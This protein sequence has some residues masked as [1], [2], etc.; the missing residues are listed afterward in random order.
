AEVTGQLH[1]RVLHVEA[2][3][4]GADPDAQLAVRG[5][6]P[7]VARGHVLAVDPYRQVAV[8]PARMHL[9]PAREGRIRRLVAA[10]PAQDAAPAEGVYDQRRR[11]VAAV[12][13]DR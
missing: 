1:G 9:E 11:H 13:V 5:E 6:A 12:G 10:V 8:R 2:G 4:E 3:V 7:A